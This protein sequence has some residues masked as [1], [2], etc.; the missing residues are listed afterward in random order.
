VSRYVYL[1]HYS[2]E[3]FVV[4]ASGFGAAQKA[5]NDSDHIDTQADRIEC[6]GEVDAEEAPDADP[7]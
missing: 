4:I 5:L 6:V 1:L 7:R 3:A 2:D